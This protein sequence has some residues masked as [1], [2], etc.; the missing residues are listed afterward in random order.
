M[1]IAFL[2]FLLLFAAA[3]PVRARELMVCDDVSDPMTLDPQKQFSEKN[4]TV[5]QQIFDGLIRLGPDGKIEPALAVSWEKISDTRT[6]FRLRE[7]VFFHNGEPFDSGAVKFSIERY[8]DPATGFPA[9]GFIGSISGAEIVDG[10]TVDIVTKYPDALMLNRLAGFILMVPPKYIKEH[11]TEH[12][13]QNPVGTGA[14]VFDKWQKGKALRLSA[15]KKYWLSGFPKADGLVFKFIP[16]E[17]QLQALFSGEVDLLT[18]LPGTQTL[19]VTENP[20]LTVLKKPSFY[21]MPF[22]LNLSSGPLSSLEVR[23]ALNHAVDKEGLVRYALLGNGQ[24]IATL[25]MPGETGHNASLRPYEYNPEKARKLM[26]KAGYPRGFVMEF[27][28]KKNAERTAKIVAANL[29]KIGVNLNIT[30][31]SD[32][33]MIKEFKSGKYDMFIGSSSDPMGHAYFIQAIVLYSKSPFAWGGDPKF[34]GMLVDM[35]T[36]G[37]GD[38]VKMAEELDKYVYDNA[39]SIFTY[40]KSMVYGVTRAL[41]VTPYVSGMPYFFSAHFSGGAQ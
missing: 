40:Q 20:K 18:D 17:K 12:F 37:A 9:L 39:M 11:G 25:S 31:V 30:L 29:K 23:K 1:R 41:S 19:K 21:T 36:A 16:Y 33:D 15:N 2:A 34:D 4:H 32:A 22:A 13:A 6:R 35:V 8:L 3:G 10:L 24:P 5:C 7:G 28:V 38:S 27:L 26:V 14:F